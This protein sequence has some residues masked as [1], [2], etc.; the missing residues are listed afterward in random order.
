MHKR[1]Y[2]APELG[3]HTTVVITINHISTLNQDLSLL[4]QVH[5]C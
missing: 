1:H 2:S 4:S 5:S 3:D